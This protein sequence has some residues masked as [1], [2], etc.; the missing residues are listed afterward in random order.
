MARRAWIAILS[1]GL[2]LFIV[3]TAFMVW[4][5]ATSKGFWAALG[6]LLWFGFL[7]WDVYLALRRRILSKP[8]KQAL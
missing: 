6:A 5:A 2:F 8:D 1:F 4:Y 3:L 7:T